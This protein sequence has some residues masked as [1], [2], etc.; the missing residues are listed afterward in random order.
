MNKVNSEELVVIRH[1]LQSGIRLDERRAH[2]HRSYKTR[3][4]NLPLYDANVSVSLGN[5]ELTLYFRY[6]ETS[7]IV[8]TDM[9]DSISFDNFFVIK[10][11]LYKLFDVFKLGCIVEYKVIRDDGS[12][13]SLFYSAFDRILRSIKLPYICDNYE[14]VKDKNDNLVFKT[15][16]SN[17]FVK[18]DS[19]SAITY[20]LIDD[21]CIIDPTF[22]EEQASDAVLTVL[23]QG[24]TM[25]GLYLF[26]EHGIALETLNRFLENDL[27][28]K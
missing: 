14:F 27:L 3:E 2:E 21:F 1:M 22:V 4:D 11:R 20:G 6:S 17:Y 12:L 18:M 24:D 8:E 16:N 25:N 5:S 10:D 26:S 28:P 15:A 9:Q 7:R 23:H 19:V 13:L